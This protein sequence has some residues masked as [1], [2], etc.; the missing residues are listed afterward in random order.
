MLEDDEVP[1][2]NR[3]DL[4]RTYVIANGKGGVGKTTLALASSIAEDSVCRPVSKSV[5][6]QQAR[7]CRAEMTAP[8]RLPAAET[9]GGRSETRAGPWR[10][11]ADQ[12]F[13]SA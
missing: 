1:L 10:A 8:E 9:R 12:A 3:D 13:G 5:G 4:S 6:D 2:F 7:D 11:S